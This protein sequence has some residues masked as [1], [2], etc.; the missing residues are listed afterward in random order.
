METR[1]DKLK[2]DWDDRQN[3]MGLTKRAVLFKRFPSV[4]NES[5]H[6]RHTAFVLQNI[7]TDVKSLLD[8]G[9]GY[10]R[11][12]AEIQRQYPSI[13]FHGVDL[14]TEFAHAYEKEFGPCFNGPIQSFSTDKRFDVVISV[15]CLMYLDLAEHRPTL[16]RL[17]SILN[18][19]GC[20]VCIEPAIEILQLWRK[21]TRRT[22]ASPTGGSV[23]HFHQNELRELCCGLR[24]AVLQSTISVNLVPFLSSTAL[25]HGVSV[26]KIG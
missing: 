22:N 25:H 23:H 20:L 17:W 15:T 9:C 26:R 13:A 24:A 2:R 16:E 8:V 3:Q 21:L 11:I 10:G 1:I 19:G 4:I 18:V 12:S 6:R 14:C 5:I 7:S